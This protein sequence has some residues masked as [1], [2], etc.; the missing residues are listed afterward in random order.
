[1]Q[2]DASLVCPHCILDLQKAAV[3]QKLCCKFVQPYCKVGHHPAQRWYRT[4]Y[5]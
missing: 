3:V 4:Q 2:A 1:M 5:I